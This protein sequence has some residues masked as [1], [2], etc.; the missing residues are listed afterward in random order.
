MAL[1]CLQPR[2][3]PSMPGWCRVALRS[4]TASTEANRLALPPLFACKMRANGSAQG[5]G[6]RTAEHRRDALT[7]GNTPTCHHRARVITDQ[8]LLLIC[9]FG[10]QVPGGAPCLTWPFAVFSAHAKTAPRGQTGRMRARSE[11]GLYAPS[12][13]PKP[14]GAWAASKMHHPRATS[15]RHAPRICRPAMDNIAPTAGEHAVL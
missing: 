1:F 14:A 4:A 9:G 12:P 10:V 13:G 11:H 5:T 6:Y 7:C 3:R 15:R 8:V 2:R